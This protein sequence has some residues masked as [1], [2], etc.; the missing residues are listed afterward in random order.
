MGGKFVSE[1]LSKIR[2]SVWSSTEG[3]VNND[4]VLPGDWALLKGGSTSKPVTEQGPAKSLHV[5]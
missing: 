4:L 3:A 5:S 1:H 2:K